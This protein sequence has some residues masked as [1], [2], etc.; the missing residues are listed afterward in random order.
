MRKLSRRVLS[1]KLLRAQ[2]QRLTDR[3]AELLRGVSRNGGEGMTAVGL[4]GSDAGRAF[5]L[6]DAALADIG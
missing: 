5:L 3:Y 1:D 2:A 6:L 4:L